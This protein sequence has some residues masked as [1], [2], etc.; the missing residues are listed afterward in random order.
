MPLVAANDAPVATLRVGGSGGRIGVAD[1][2]GHVLDGAAHVR[3]ANLVGDSLEVVD[4]DGASK[5]VIVADLG[6]SAVLILRR[7]L[8]HNVSCIQE[9]TIL[10]LVEDTCGGHADLGGGDRDGGDAGLA[11]GSLL[12]GDQVKRV[13]RE[14]TVGVDHTHIADELVVDH[15]VMRSSV[16]RGSQEI[17]DGGEDGDGVVHVEVSG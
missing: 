5:E 12:V 2:L 7:L 8:A 17:T 10:Y 13:T 15:Q 11:L 14:V 1:D 4:V 16:D 3:A 9:R 6:Q